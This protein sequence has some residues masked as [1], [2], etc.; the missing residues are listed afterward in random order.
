MVDKTK[1]TRETSYPFITI[2]AGS[3]RQAKIPA[4]NGEKAGVIPWQPDA[5][6]PGLPKT[7]NVLEVDIVYLWSINGTFIIKP[8]N[9]TLYAVIFHLSLSLDWTLLYCPHF[10]VAI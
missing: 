6:P 2:S 4:V 1:I 10:I 9:Y 5:L 8:L 7:M 3:I